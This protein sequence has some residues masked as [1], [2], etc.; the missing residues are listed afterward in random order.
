M[1][2]SGSA[3][4][5][6][7]T[8]NGQGTKENL[9][10][11]KIL[12]A[13]TV[14]WFPTPRLVMALARAGFYVEAVCP[15]K[16]PL[17]KTSVIHKIHSYDGFVPT[18]SFSDA[19]AASAPDL[20]VPG[21]EYAV[22]CL[23]KVYDRAAGDTAEP[24]R[25]LIEKSLGPSESFRI[26]ASRTAVMQLAREESIRV[27]RTEV[28]RN[29]S[30]LRRCSEE[31][32]FPFVLKADGTSSGEGVRI[33]R[34]IEEAKR[35]FRTLRAPLSAV[36]VV[37]RVLVDQ[38]R[39]FVLPTLLRQGHQ[40]NAQE[41]VDGTDATSMAA[42]W[43]GDVLA[44]IHFEVVKKQYKNG[45]ASVMRRMELPEMDLAIS[46]VVKRL[47]LSGFHGFDFLI[48]KGSGNPFLVEV[49]PRPTQVGHLTL[50][51]GRDLPAALYAAVANTPVAE[52][53]P[54]TQNDTIALFP[55]EWV[56]NPSSMFLRSAYHDIPWE[57]PELIRAG[58]RQSRGWGFWSRGRKWAT[59]LLPD[60][61]SNE[62]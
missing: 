55:Q 32:L 53:P 41:L 29:V 24:I 33:V 35:G 3:Q 18:V 36:R 5:E 56:R 34:T 26:L 54:I 1:Y 38:E 57:E 16:H 11:P 21:D 25:R 12:I 51:A 22:Q 48:E 45:P 28:I 10:A 61:D 17:Q 9:L 59:L 19:I 46:R 50:G 20:V 60:R 40:V 6:V 52:A 44:R 58:T 4:G 8:N 62:P 13:T 47:N 23:R 15:R 49:N 31:F 7:P 39:E 42:C 2:I 27:P 30:D 43:R 14:R 37:K